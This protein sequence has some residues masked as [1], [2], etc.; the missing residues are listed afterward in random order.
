M[1]N[2]T[3]L[4]TYIQK[5]DSNHIEPIYVPACVGFPLKQMY[6]G[7]ARAVVELQ[8][9]KSAVLK[10]HTGAGKTAT[11]LTLAHGRS[12]L[13][14]EPRKFLQ[15]QVASYRGDTIL[16]GRNEYPC[17]L[18]EH[19]GT[20]PCIRKVR[21]DRTDYGKT[22]ENRQ[23]GCQSNP[24][25]LFLHEGELHRYPC[26]SCPYN[27]AVATAKGV[28]SH[29]GTVICNFGNF[30]KFVDDAELII[31][32]EADLFYKEISSPELMRHCKD[33]DTPIVSMI[34]TEK[35]ELEAQK[36]T[37]TSKQFYAIQNKLY[38]LAFLDRVA[39]LCFT[40]KKRNLKT[41]TESI[42]VEVDPLNVTLLHDQIFNGKQ[43]VIVSA[44]PGEFKLP[45][46]NYSIHQRCGIYYVPQGKLTSRELN[47]QPWLLD[48]AAEF[49][50]Q[51]S[52]IF[53]GLYNSKKF[54]V[55]CGNIGMHA[56]RI[57]E[58][59]NDREKKDVCTLHQAG[60]LMGTID[61]FME[62][63]K[64]YLLVASAEYGADFSWCNCQFILKFPYA[65]Y[66]E[67]MKALERKLG[68][69]EFSKFY[70]MDAINRTIQQCGRVGRGWDSFGCTFILDAKFGE[71]YKVYKNHFPDW[72]RKRYCEE[73]F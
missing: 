14:I 21:C 15:K 6:D 35:R 53:G 60:N 26:I 52:A 57:N 67:R 37:C 43:T 65:S 9:H 23:G 63:N 31:I 68:K 69:V 73:A 32:D 7:Q 42:Y 51:A 71:I 22:C 11:F 47:R 20:A 55:H 19:A 10:S 36:Q 1:V 30:W 66:D 46:V 48:H 18:A 17:F 13:I 5:Q 34:A 49:I 12:T 64:K 56:T 38:R 4:L 33:P 59:L 45:S 70:T 2:W 50:D 3:E 16:F 25:K 72:F 62:S 41:K 24:C 27:N 44:T 61:T 39:S 29:G 40:Y 54:V 58:L 28:I 8:Q